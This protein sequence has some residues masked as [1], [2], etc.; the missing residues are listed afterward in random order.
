M[1]EKPSRACWVE[2]M[3]QFHKMPRRNAELAP[4]CWAL[5]G[6]IELMKGFCMDLKPPAFRSRSY[7]EEFTGL[8]K[9]P[10]VITKVVLT[11]HAAING[12]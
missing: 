9:P 5:K 10:F 2:T 1:L 8:I 6:A 3:P 4:K 12:A 7:G 11:G